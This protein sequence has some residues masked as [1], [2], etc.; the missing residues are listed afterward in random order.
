MVKFAGNAKNEGDGGE[1]DESESMTNPQAPDP[2][3]PSLPE[4][5]YEPN[6][7]SR[8]VVIEHDEFIVRIIVR[9]KGLYAPVPTWVS[10]LDLLTII[11]WPIYW[12]SVIV[13]RF[14]LHRPNPSRAIFEIDDQRM[15][16]MLRDFQTGECTTRG[17][18]RSAVV[19]ARANRFEKGL[20]IDVPGHVKETVLTDLP[21]DTIERLDA[22][23]NEALGNQKP[24][25]PE[26]TP[27]GSV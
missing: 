21:R 15:K 24:S 25:D 12:L 2:D 8:P 3:T 11:V 23:I 13:W 26:G 16:M 20:W 18:P 27:R 19:A 14:L 22:A 10:N 9:S 6:V 5:Q 1:N 17:W 4:L 7:S